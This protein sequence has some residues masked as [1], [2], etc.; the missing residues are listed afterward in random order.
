MNLTAELAVVDLSSHARHL[1]DLIWG[2]FAEFSSHPF[3][4][5]SSKALANIRSG[6]YFPLNSFHYN[7]IN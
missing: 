6:E 3:L 4:P 7:G 5:G 1:A 2:I